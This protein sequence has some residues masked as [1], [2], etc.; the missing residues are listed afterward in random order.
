M[1]ISIAVLFT[2]TATLI[3]A[4]LRPG[5]TEGASSSLAPRAGVTI[6]HAIAIENQIK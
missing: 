4:S 6:S 5:G 2:S 3:E 1:C